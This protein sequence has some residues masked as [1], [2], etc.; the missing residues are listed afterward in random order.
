[1]RVA[2]YVHR[3]SVHDQNSLLCP[4]GQCSATNHHAD[5]NT[6]LSDIEE[7]SLECCKAKAFDDDVGEDTETTNDEGA[8]DLQENVT[9]DHGVGESFEHL[10]L[11]VHFILNP[12]FVCSDSFHH[13][14]FLFF[15][16]A[17][18]L[19]RRVGKPPR[20]EQRPHAG[21]KA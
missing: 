12:G 20:D 9:P 18:R 7:L 14:A 21:S 15:G 1:M 11:L 13:Q 3:P 6:A 17:F 4:R 8:A 2:L 16:E 10:V 5:S 19:H